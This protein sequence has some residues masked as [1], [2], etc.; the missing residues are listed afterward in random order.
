MIFDEEG[1][2]KKGGWGI[3][4]CYCE[5]ASNRIVDF[6]TIHPFENQSKADAGNHLLNNTQLDYIYEPCQSGMN[7][8]VKEEEEEKKCGRKG[9]RTV[10][11]GH[12]S[13]EIEMQHINVRKHSQTDDGID[14]ALFDDLT[15][16]FP[17]H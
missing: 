8:A 16:R 14:G 5:A 12:V 13:L 3:V 9:V 6:A 4:H 7:C 15:A 1:S 11:L 2:K 10:S 17:A